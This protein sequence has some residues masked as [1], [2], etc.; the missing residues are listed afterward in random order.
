M[1]D[2]EVHLGSKIENFYDGYGKERAQFSNC[3]SGSMEMPFN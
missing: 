1:N 3:A 2:F